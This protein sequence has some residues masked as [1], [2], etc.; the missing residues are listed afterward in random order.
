MQGV[1]LRLSGLAFALPPFAPPSVIP[2]G[3]LV[4]RTS[5]TR[6][7]SI[8]YVGVALPIQGFLLNGKEVE[9]M[10]ESMYK[11]LFNAITEAVEILKKA[12]SDT[13]EIFV[14]D[15]EDKPSSALI[16]DQD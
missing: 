14:S 2:W 4:A 16:F 5:R 9:G 13:E 11:R 12:Q 10:Y 3:L 8:I 6:I 1:A 15:K 7:D